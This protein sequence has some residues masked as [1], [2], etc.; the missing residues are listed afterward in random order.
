VGFRP[1]GAFNAPA[2]PPLNPEVSFF[3]FLAGLKAKPGRPE[4]VILESIS[5]IAHSMGK[6]V[7]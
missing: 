3:I 6:I 5:P 2:S 4:E 7:F 1:F